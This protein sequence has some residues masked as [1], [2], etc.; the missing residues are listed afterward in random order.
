MARQ[1]VGRGTTFF[2]AL[3]LL[4]VLS[5]CGAWGMGSGRNR[6]GSESYASNGERIYWSATSERDTPIVPER[7]GGMMM[8]RQDLACVDCHGMDGRGGDVR[9]GMHL[10][11]VPDIRY[12]VLTGE[13]M[14]HDEEEEHPPYTDSTIRRAITE[15]VDPA[16]KP[17]DWPMPRW[18][19][20]DADL[21]DLI[22]YLKQLSGR[23]TQRQAPEGETNI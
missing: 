11:E 17:L 14:E 8:M 15:G 9:F 7:A 21:D 2:I 16:G 4:A 3:A 20:L 5:G 13:S 1:L 12:E 10:V 6:P 23:S 18:R 22:E 19:I